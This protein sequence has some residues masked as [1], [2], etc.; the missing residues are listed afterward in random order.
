M[1]AEETV[2]V[3]E[4]AE[5]YS[6][7]WWTVSTRW[8]Q[9]PTWPESVGRKGNAKLYLARQVEAW[10]EGRRL[11]RP[12]EAPIFTRDPDELIDRPTIVQ[13]SGL[14]KGTI[15]A[16]F[17]QGLLVPKE[18]HALRGNT[19]VRR[20]GDIADQLRKRNTYRKKRT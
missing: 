12:P 19:K 10:I 3:E 16:N 2:T 14:A 4:I 18:G 7:S 1:V 13:E 17:S 6:V 20:R 11:T 15:Y 5:R 9:D 8:T